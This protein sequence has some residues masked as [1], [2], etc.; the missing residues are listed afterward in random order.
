MINDGA[1]D[2]YK[3]LVFLWG[4]TTE[5]SVLDRM[6]Q[7]VVKGGTVIYPEKQQAREG[8]LSTIEGDLSVWNR[9]RQGQTGRG[10]LLL[11]EGHPEPIHYYVTFLRDQLRQL[12][13]LSPA[14]RAAI[15]IEKPVEVYWSV[16]KN[17]KLA[18]MN[19][20]DVDAV[21]QLSSGKQLT[22]PPYTIVLASI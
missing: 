8:G 1:L 20:D 17:G 9:W 19:Y 5:K 22:I 16:L 12:E 18:L 10:R 15:R 3:V 14:V 7:W 13:V 11:F 2:R 21:V 6:D 4:R